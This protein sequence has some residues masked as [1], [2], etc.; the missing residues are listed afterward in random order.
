MHFQRL[1]T[2]AGVV[3]ERRGHKALAGTKVRPN[4][5]PECLSACLARLSSH[6]AL[7]TRTRSQSRF[8]HTGVSR[9]LVPQHRMRLVR[10]GEL[11]QLLG[12]E[13]QIAGAHGSFDLRHLAGAD[14]RCGD[15]RLVQGQRLHAPEPVVTCLA[16]SPPLYRAASTLGGRIHRGIQTSARQA[17]LDSGRE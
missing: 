17:S 1:N 11:L 3:R 9:L 4:A 7:K 14:D 13:L 10:C 8:L 6:F 5:Y 2:T 15:A 12:D 16:R